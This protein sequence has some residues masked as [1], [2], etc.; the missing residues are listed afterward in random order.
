MNQSKNKN[1]STLY[2]HNKPAVNTLLIILLSICLICVLSACGASEKKE[3]DISNDL[4]LQDPYFATYHLNMDS[5][6]I[7][8]RQTNLEDKTDYI[9]CEVTASNDTF[10]Y[11]AEYELTYVLYNDGWLLEE[12]NQ[13]SS[14]VIP[15]SLPTQT[16]DEAKAAV[17][18]DWKA[19]HPDLAGD[20]QVLK[21]SLQKISDLTYAY[22]FRICRYNEYG[23]PMLPSDYAVYYNFDVDSGQWTVTID[24]SVHLTWN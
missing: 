17:M 5:F 3:K 4:Q 2:F 20:H 16:Q 11:V 15:A 14:S 7:S 21:S 10:S 8:K 19:N 1:F 22:Y 6:S 9:W 18:A 24:S 13:I 23:L 12:Y